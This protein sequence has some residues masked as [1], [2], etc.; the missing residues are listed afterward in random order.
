MGARGLN[1]PPTKF[2]W[3]VKGTEPP[4]KSIWSSALLA[5]AAAAP[6][7]DALTSAAAAREAEWTAAAAAAAT[8]QAPVRADRPPPTCSAEPQRAN[9]APG[10]REYHGQEVVVAAALGVTCRPCCS[11]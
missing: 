2:N 7:A 1:E 5:G 10:S 8:R 4:G 11:A 9:I 3:L 6:L